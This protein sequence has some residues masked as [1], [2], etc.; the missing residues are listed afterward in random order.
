MLSYLHVT[1]R[2]LIMGDLHG[3]YQQLLT[4]LSRLDFSPEQ[5]DRLIAL[6]DLTDRGADNLACLRLLQQPW[7]HSIRGNHEQLMLLALLGGSR[8]A[9]QLWFNNGGCW[10]EQLAEIEQA[11]VMALCQER[12]LHL[13]YAM[14]I[15][16]R[17]HHRIG[18]VHA[19][20]VFN[21]WQQLV[22]CLRAPSP[23]PAILEQLLWQRVRLKQLRQLLRPHASSR[24]SMTEAPDIAR[25]AGIDLV[26]MGHTPLSGEAPWGTGNMLWLDNGTCA[27]FELVILDA[28]DWLKHHPQPSATNTHAYG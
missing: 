4:R 5:G 28:D 13:S 24:L 10:Y 3:C 14:E 16:S 22:E 18:L 8:N 15:T 19:D 25:I 27:G 17:D 23:D 12:I 11:E 6:G 7:F 9:K 1:G 2:T 20:P 21:H 26:C